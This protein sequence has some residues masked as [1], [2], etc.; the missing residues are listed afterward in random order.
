MK[1]YWILISVGVL[2]AAAL[3]ILFPWI[4]GLIPVAGRGV[5]EVISLPRDLYRERSPAGLIPARAGL[6]IR[7][8]SALDVWAGL[9]AR[10][11]FRELTVSPLWREEKIEE[12]LAAARQDFEVR[13]G[14]RIDRSRIMDV[15]GQDIALAVI[16]SAG[17]SPDALLVVTRLG[18]RAR[19]TEIVLRLG[20]A[21]KGEPDRFLREEKYRGE[22]IAV[23]PSTEAFPLE[24]A[25]AVIDGYLA[26]A[27]SGSARALVEEVI[28]LARGEGEPL[29]AFP[30]FAA[31]L[32]GS[33]FP[34]GNF[35]ECYLSPSRFGGGLAKGLP[36]G[37]AAEAAAWGEVFMGSL[38][39]CRTIG[40]RAGYREGVHSRLRIALE[41]EGF[42]GSAVRGPGAPGPLP[43][44][45]MLYGFFAAEPA[46]VG[47]SLEV[48]LTS[49]GVREEAG[50]FPGLGEWERESGL[51]LLRDILPVLGERWSLVFE[52]LTG[53]EFIP[54]PPFALV[55]RVADRAAAEAVLA[56]VVSWA[57]RT[58]GLRSVRE[59]Y[60][61]VE[62]TSFPGLFFSEPGYAISGDELVIAW[63]RP[64]LK[65][66][67]DFQ[68]EGSP[69]VENDPIFQR[70]TSAFAPDAEA[71]LYLEGKSFLSSI[72]AAA[73]WYFAYQRL[74]PE[75]P[76][77]PERI[78]R[79]K[80]V[81]LLDLLR[82]IRGAAA[83]LVREKNIVKTD[84]FLYIPEPD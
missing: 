10:R 9:A 82:P 13:T 55:N 8:R 61:G 77:I 32:D 41:G 43:A 2:A 47:E 54:L 20:D 34:P 44:G 46:A 69:A 56:G 83:K 23:I 51:S 76:I 42:P 62:M 49:L 57:V 48:L 70:I 33:G 63:S 3:L 64:M 7:V 11:T 60:N 29:D 14:F 35:L 17:D 81:P 4:R 22:T 50:V 78:Y 66:I 84:C 52:G 53:G 75:E 19:L 15:A 59:V 1:K 30:E 80:I 73:E 16:P 68:V 58:R 37:P 12:R 36:P 18:V 5:V 28:D 25:Y 38:G 72:R 24:A 65:R 45:G 67:I 39:S 6:M 40:F 79:K 71:L 31:T 27:V 21:L 26:V 74:V